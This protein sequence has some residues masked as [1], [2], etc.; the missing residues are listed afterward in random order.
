MKNNQFKIDLITIVTE[1]DDLNQIVEKT[2]TDSTIYAEIDSVTQT[3]F[4]SAGRLGFQPDFKATIYDFEYSGQKILKY[5]GK[6]YS[7]YRTY[8]IDGTD[9]VELYCTERGGTKDAPEQHSDDQSS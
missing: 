2:R 6:L 9:R 3:E 5:N 8:Y 1:T 4:F 7:I